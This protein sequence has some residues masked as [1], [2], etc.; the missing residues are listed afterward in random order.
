MIL[1][2]SG[3]ASSASSLAYLK[4]KG[5]LEDAVRS[6][7]FDNTVI[8]RPG[9]L[10]GKRYVPRHPIL[11]RLRCVCATSGTCL[12][13]GRAETQGEKQECRGRYREA[14]LSGSPLVRRP[15]RLAG[16]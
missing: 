13:K 6:L 10:M 3:G 5:Q 11:R 7:G 4:M 9:F 2:S 16:D 14:A 1:V 8:L 12:S 15:D